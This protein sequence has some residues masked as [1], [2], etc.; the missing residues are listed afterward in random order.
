MRVLLDLLIL[1]FIDRTFDRPIQFFGK[2][3][4]MFF[5]FSFLT[6]AWALGLKYFAGASLIQTPLPL[7]SATIGLS[8][9]L[10]I[11]LGVIAEVQARIYFEA[12]G[13]P[14]YKVKAVVQ[15]SAAPLRAEP[16][17]W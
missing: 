6:F 14:P 12:R 15:N 2:L 17:R 3:G 16:N 9:I 13:R 10:F 11:L 4:L 5:G 7:L 1:Y 8:G